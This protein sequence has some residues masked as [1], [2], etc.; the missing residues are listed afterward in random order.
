MLAPGRPSTPSL[1]GSGSR[2]VSIKGIDVLFFV[3]YK[4]D[5]G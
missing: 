3:C 1:A 4:V 2:R 5:D